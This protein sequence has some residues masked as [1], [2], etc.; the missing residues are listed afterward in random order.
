MATIP[1]ILTYEEW[2]QMPPAEDGSREEIVNGEL[3]RLPPNKVT[4]AEVIHNLAFAISRQI[5]RKLISVIES[6]VTLLISTEP[7]AARAPDLIV[8]WRKNIV[9][10]HHDVLCSPPDLLVEVLSPSETKRRK[11]AKLADYARIGVPEVWFVSPATHAVEILLLKNGQ[12]MVDTVATEGALHPIRF[13]D[14]TIS[15]DEIWP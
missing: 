15:V 13:P 9:L 6:S 3:L 4:H 10:D 12:L 5:D 8:S 7:L 11:Q 14:V 1:R 2:L